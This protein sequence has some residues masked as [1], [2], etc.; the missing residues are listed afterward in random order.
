MLQN[1]NLTLATLNCVREKDSSSSPYL[2]PAVIV[3]NEASL[4]VF[5]V[6]PL[7]SNDR[8]VIQ[9]NLQAG[10]SAPIPSSVGA[11]T[12][13]FDPA[14]KTDLILVVALLQKHDTPGNAVDAGFEAFTDTLQSAV[15][16]NLAGLAS[17]D[18]QQ[19]AIDKIKSTVSDSVTSAEW[20]SLST[21]QKGEVIIGA[22]T[23]DSPVD[24]SSQFVAL[25][26][27]SFTVT[28]GGPLGGR[29]LSYGDSGTPGNVSNPL[30][31]GFGGWS[32]FKFLF[33]GRD[34]AGN[35][36]IYA[37]NNNGELLSYGD[38]ETPG[39]VS[40]PVVV[41]FGG[42]LDF[43][44]LFAGGD[45]AGN[46]RIYAVNSNGE[47]LSYGDN[48]TPGNVSNP[49]VVGFGGWL[50]FKF[51]FAG[52]DLAGNNRIYAVNNNGQLLSYGDSGTPGNVSNPVVVGFGGWSGFKFLFAG[53]D[54]AGNNRIYAVNANGELLS[55]G[56]SGT[57]GNVSSPVTVGFGG[58]SDFNFLFAGTDLAGNNR[59]YV[60]EKALTPDH[61]YE[62]DCSLQIEAAIC[63]NE[64][65]TVLKAKAAVQDLNNQ[66]ATLQAQ[67]QDA[68]GA[69]KQFYLQE[70]R[71]LE[72]NQLAPA[73]AALDKAEQDL[74]ACLAR[75]GS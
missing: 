5:V 70:I 38:N 50:G 4:S 74:A 41:G 56:D 40:S 19:A 32:G 62:I 35:N 49:V 66:L 69:Q 8:V 59:I 27:A 16:A 15:L 48:G 13:Q 43:K 17:P 26:P 57:P 28:I 63:V 1:A 9:N 34:V 71:D 51:L 11:L 72:K 31:V 25:A 3:I 29:L 46:N 12:V 65:D 64:R 24:S 60:A 61:H 53:R 22:L 21:I 58:W 20:N 73:Q 52:V 10:Q 2:W 42:W 33:A 36:R 47:L 37:V 44:F 30:V 55:Y 54:A 7:I 68:V 23:L 67:A 75:G 6:S 18:T 14:T 45:V 39:N